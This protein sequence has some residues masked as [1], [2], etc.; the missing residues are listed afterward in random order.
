MGRPKSH[1]PKRRSRSPFSFA[2]CGGQSFR[3]SD[4]PSPESSHGSELDNGRI[5]PTLVVRWDAANDCFAESSLAPFI[6]GIGA[7]RAKFV[8]RTDEDRQEF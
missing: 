3:T 2:Y 5:E 8:A 6:G 1:P 7:A 4:W